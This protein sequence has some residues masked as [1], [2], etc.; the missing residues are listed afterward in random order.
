MTEPRYSTLDP[1]R[2]AGCQGT[3][4]V[5]KGRMP[6][7]LGYWLPIYLCENDLCPRFESAQ[8]IGKYPMTPEDFTALQASH[9]NPIFRARPYPHRVV[10]VGRITI[11]K[12][13][14]S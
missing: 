6:S 3:D 1:I 14:R 4:L 13:G 2:C 10:T 5:Y 8:E 12:E 11:I 7:T 9:H